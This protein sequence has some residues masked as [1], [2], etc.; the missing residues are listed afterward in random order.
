MTANIVYPNSNES[1]TA[2]SFNSPSDYNFMFKEVDKKNIQ[3]LVT[4]IQK[5]GFDTYLSGILAKEVPRYNTKESQK[6]Y[7]KI[8][9][10]G[11]VGEEPS[12]LHEKIESLT[13]QEMK[14]TSLAKEL[15]GKDFIIVA[16]T[17]RNRIGKKIPMYSYMFSWKFNAGSDICLGIYDRLE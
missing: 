1:N 12:K 2:L 14:P 13:D 8:I 16:P 5:E 15:L 6:R 4:L 7:P 9:N 10:L 17:P 3:N 11:A